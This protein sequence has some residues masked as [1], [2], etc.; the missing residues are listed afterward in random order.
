MTVALGYIR[1]A[2][3][4][5][6][7]AVVPASFAAR[8]DAPAASRL[9]RL[10][11]AALVAALTWVALTPRPPLLL[12]DTGW[13][14]ANHALAFAVLAANAALAWRRLPRRALV[15]AAALLAYGVLIE[16]AQSFVP[17]RDA[18]PLDLVADAAGIAAGLAALRALRL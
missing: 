18:E 15:C 8:I 12:L 11:L 6:I 13:D 9:L 1:A 7:A 3:D 16:F 17:G 14:K 2:A 10:L 4:G 5:T